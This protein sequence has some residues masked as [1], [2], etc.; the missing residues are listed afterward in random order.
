MKNYKFIQSYMP[1]KALALCGLLFAPAFTGCNKEMDDDFGVGGAQERV[2]VPT[3]CPDPELKVPSGT[4]VHLA[5]T[6]EGASIYYTQGEEDVGEPSAESTPYIDGNAESYPVIA[7]DDG[8]VITVKAIAIKGGLSSDVAAFAYTVDNKADPPLEGNVSVDGTAYIGHT[9]NAVTSALVYDETG[10]LSYQ[11]DVAGTVKGTAAS[12]TV[13]AADFHKAITLSVS[14]SKN[15]GSITDTATES[16]RG[17][18]LADLPA[19]LGAL[20]AG[21]AASP[22]VVPL[23]ACSISDDWV[24]VNSYIEAAKKYVALDLTDCTATDNTIW[25]SYEEPSDSDF[26]II[27]NNVY[28]KGV[29]LPSSLTCIGANA[30]RDCKKITSVII[31]DSVTSI[32]HHAFAGSGITSIA[33]PDSVTDM[34]WD[35][36]NGCSSLAS[37]QLGNGISSINARLFEDCIKLEAIVIPNGVSDIHDSAFVKCRELASVTLPDSLI[38]IENNAFDFCSILSSVTIP[39]GVTTLEDEVFDRCSNLTTVVFAEGSNI[40]SFG[41]NAFPQGNGGDG[42]DAL[43]TAYNGA[44]PHAGTYTRP[45]L[46]S[47]WAKQ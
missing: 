24:T 29:I 10:T 34:E 31:P 6:T 8:D 26:N 25:S 12:Y 13:E 18:P 40:A 4:K 20:D 17:V 21:G 35:V 33:V 37:A 41:N 27:M 47:V 32:G 36:F 1:F 9:L 45:D 2:A 46:G 39:A 23:D 15:S 42:G 30:F 5:T 22:N 14:A 19:Y 3:T 43:K 16:A 38:N 28:I 11:W 44:S 7:G